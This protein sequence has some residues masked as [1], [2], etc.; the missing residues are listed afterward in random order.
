VDVVWDAGTWTLPRTMFGMIPK[1]TAARKSGTM[2]MGP[3][4]PKAVV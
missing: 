4:F 1:V 2:S 3:R